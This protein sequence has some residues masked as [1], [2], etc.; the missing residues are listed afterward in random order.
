MNIRLTTIERAYEIAR[1]GQVRTVTEIRTQL[2]AEGYT[3]AVAQIYGN[4]LITDLRR[5]CLAARESPQ[6]LQ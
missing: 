6:P 4:A 1:S 2:R 3:D 5:L